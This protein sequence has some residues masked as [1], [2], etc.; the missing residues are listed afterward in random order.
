MDQYRRS[1]QLYIVEA[2]L[3]YL[4]SILVTGSFFATLTKQLGMSDSLTGILSSVISLGCLFQLFSVA[5]RRK[6]WKP[7][8]LVMSILNQLLFFALYIIPLA[9]GSSK[10]RTGVFV[11]V[12]FIAYLLYYIAHP[13]KVYW[14]MSLVDDGSRGIFT[15]HKEMVSLVAGMIFSFLMGALVDHFTQSG[16][17]SMA[18]ILSAAVMLI[19]IVLHTVVM[20]S[21]DERPM[22]E[23]GKKCITEN[24]KDVISN[25]NILSVTVIFI[26]YYISTYCASPFYGTYTINELGLNLKYVAILSMA[27][28]ISRIMVSVFWG[29]YADR[30]SFAAMIEKCFVILAISYLC[31]VFA[32]PSNGK[33][34]FA[35]YYIFHGIAL[36]GVNSALTNLIFDYV[37]PTKRA[38][39][40]A[41]CQAAAGLLGFVATLAVSPLITF[42]QGNQN[43][44]FG[45]PMYAQQF[46]SIMSFVCMLVAIV[47]VRFVVI[48]KNKKEK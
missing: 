39:S 11:A 17:T 7:F 9:G 6:K 42:I 10:L 36:G 40:L 45:L 30:N 8:V 44:I 24:I 27:G 20:A 12:I 46:V 23:P 4:V 14:L 37:E 19:L 31:V 43:R 21:T 3:E 22:P 16:Q 26:L 41:I 38:D 35:L 28:S 29:R 32:V 15:A 2:A 5:L 47:Y 33:I 18:F 34:M 1:R 25:K 13:K 48:R